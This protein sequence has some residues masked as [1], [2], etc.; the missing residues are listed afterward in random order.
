M[1]SILVLVIANLKKRKIQS[2]LVMLILM[3]SVV[4]FGTSVALLNHPS[5]PF[6]NMFE[7]QKGSHVVFDLNQK[8]TN[9]ESFLSWWKR[10]HEVVDAT[11]Y[12]YV[13]ISD[14]VI[15][16]GHEKSIGSFMLAE[17]TLYDYQT[18]LLTFVE[19]NQK[20]YPLDDEIFVPTGYASNWNINLDDELTIELN[21]TEKTFVVKG[22]VVDPQ[23]SATLTSPS[24]LWIKADTLNR[25][26]SSESLNQVL[27]GV[28]LHHYGDHYET[29]MRRYEHDFGHPYFGFVYDYDFI[30]YMYTFIEGIIALLLLVF[31][32]IVLF[33][34]LLVIIFTITNRVLS[35]IQQIAIYKSIGFSNA[36]TTLVY[37]FQYVF[38]LILA[39]PFGLLIS[40]QLASLV[41][42]QLAQSVGLNS[43]N[44]DYVFITAITSLVMLGLIGMS[45]M[46]SAKKATKIKPIDAMKTS[47]FKKYKSKRNLSLV[48]LKEMPLSMMMAIQSIFSNLKHAMFILLSVVVVSFVFTFSFNM[49]HSISK[50]SDHLAMWGFD[51]SEIY[52]TS[53]KRHEEITFETLSQTLKVNPQ[54]FA[55]S[56]HGVMVDASIASQNNVS[57]TTALGFVYGGNW[58]DIGLMNI[59]GHNPV[60]KNEITISYLTAKK[61]NKSIGDT[62]IVYI[63]GIEKNMRVT[64]IYQSLNAGGWGFR[65]KAET[66]YEMDPNYDLPRYLVKLNDSK[67][68][69]SFI[70]SFNHTHGQYFNARSV[71]E[72]GE[73]NIDQIVSTMGLVALTLSFIFTIISTIIVFNFM[74]IDMIDHK[75]EYGIYKA[76][77]MDKKTIRQSLTMKIVVLSLVGISIGI[78]L[79][80]Y[81]TPS[82]LSLFLNDMG[83]IKFPFQVNALLTMIVALLV[84]LIQVFASKAASSQLKYVDLRE[85]IVC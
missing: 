13:M 77:G 76:L 54:V 2:L 6:E 46:M 69:E 65:V 85:L 38:M 57:S 5:D 15:H 11:Y 43:I 64:G 24:R 50:M 16:N 80:L 63:A 7:N 8:H 26:F 58:D 1:R 47:I 41:L 84:L 51:A 21:G 12:P 28:R 17:R 27:V 75:K 68:T 40:F 19:G 49:H 45:S 14:S 36:Q 20:D 53:N 82:I 74:M 37:V 42:E 72:S 18:D 66:V 30:V 32:L 4:L 29:L 56:I 83:L 81:L 78:P 71:K 10:Q 34:S 73:I 52:I 44:L 62:I 25:Y 35:D 70:E 3:V 55:L 33:I 67:D 59:E 23:Y 39:L 79:S 31:S 60:D 48:A 61:Y 22:I 9:L